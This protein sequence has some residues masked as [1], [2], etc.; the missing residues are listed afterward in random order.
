MAIE[1]LAI[2][3]QGVVLACLKAAAAYLDDSEKHTRLG[4]EPSALKRIIERWPAV[5]DRDHNGDDFLAINNS[6]NEV[7]HGFRIDPD[8]WN[9]WFEIPMEDVEAIYRKWLALHETEG[10]IR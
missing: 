5:D 8:D 9:T 1:R 4:I 6:Q 7:C 10:G 3:E 2:G